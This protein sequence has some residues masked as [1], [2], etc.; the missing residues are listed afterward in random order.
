VYHH[1]EFDFEGTE[2][3]FTRS[4]LGVFLCRLKESKAVYSYVRTTGVSS[5]LLYVHY[6]HNISYI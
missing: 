4:R 2:Q 6:I 5:V 1:F 3:A